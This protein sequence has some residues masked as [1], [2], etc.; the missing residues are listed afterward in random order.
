MK[1]K[2]TELIIGGIGVLAL[3]ALL[4]LGGNDGT[5]T[6]Q[7]ESSGTPVF[8]VDTKKIELGEVAVQGDYPAEFTISN[9][10]DAP[11]EISDVRTSCMCTFAEIMIGGEKSPEFNMVMHNSPT[12]RQWKGVLEPGES[13]IA[14]VIYKPHL[15]PV[16]G[17]VDRY[18][19]FT[20]NDP[21]N[22]EV[23]LGVHAI[24]K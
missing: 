7:N 12:T 21:N 18:L 1:N 13:A 17:S 8:T 11:L 16:Q 20:T 19:V 23:Q 2:S 15:M 3:G 24:V 9:T 10:G 5:E 4:L 14:R 6:A 22:R